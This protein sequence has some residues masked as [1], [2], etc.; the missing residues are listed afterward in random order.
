MQ[1]I[2]PWL[3]VAGVA[4]DLLGFLILLWE[5]WIAFFNEENQLGFQRRLEQERN[6]RAFHQA[7]VSGQL[8]QHL[9]TSGKMMDDM[10]L[11][12]AWDEHAQTMRRRKPAFLAAA[13]LIVVGSLLQIAGAWPL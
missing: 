6:R 3:S 13:A 8:R 1:D 12:R 10:A 11:R 5:W 9:E 7:N 4:I 2:Q